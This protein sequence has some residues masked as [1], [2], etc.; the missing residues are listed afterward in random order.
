M[1]ARPWET[2]QF[3]YTVARLANRRRRQTEQLLAYQRGQLRKLLRFALENSLFYRRRLRHIDPDSCSLERIPVTNKQEIMEHFDEVVT[4]RR[5]RLTEV[6]AFASDPANLGRLFLNRY[7][8]CHT[9]GSQ[10]RPI[11]IVQERKD[12]QLAFALQLARGHPL[13]K[14]W[15]TLFRRFGRPARWASFYVKPGFYPSAVVFT[16]MPRAIHRF[17]QTLR[18]SLQ[19]S[20]EKNVQKLNEFQPNF[21]TGYA[22][23]LEALAREQLAGRLRLRESGQLQMLTNMSEPLTPQARQLIE[24]TFG[25]HVSDHYAMGECM[26]LTVGCPYHRGAHVNVDLALLEVVDDRYRPVPP[27]TKGSRVLVTCLHNYVMPFIRYEIGDVIT[28]N[29]QRCPCGSNLPHVAAIEGRTKDR[30]WIRR[31]DH[32]EEFSPFIF[33]EVMYR[34]FDVAEFQFIQTDWTRFDLRVAPV[35]GRQLDVAEI[36]R[37]LQAALCEAQL[38]PLIQVNIIPVEEIRPDPVSGK[39]KRMQTL[40]APP[41]GMAA[42]TS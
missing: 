6:E 22:S 30:F 28:M 9:S 26:T 38:H 34:C 11:L 13:E 31:N 40:L 39:M 33:L 20:L 23:V 41:P 42:V 4:D 12:I 32:Y 27:G 10:G 8:I 14:R 7:V 36:Q 19:D 5:I 24:G 2:A 37:R 35:P 21:L 29:P 18:L 3:I 17:A 1:L 16:Y 15:K 25:V